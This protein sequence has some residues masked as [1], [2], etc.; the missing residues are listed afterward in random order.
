M[1]RSVL[2]K[3][4]YELLKGRK[5]NLAHLRA[6]GC[7]CFIHNND[8]DNLGK[9]YAKSDE[10]IFL[11]YSSQSKAY[12]VLNKRTNRV[13][14]SVHVVFNEHTSEVEGNSEDEQNEETCSKPSDP[15]TWEKETIPSEIGDKSA[16]ETGSSAP[17]ELVSI[18]THNWKHQSSH[19]LQN[20][21]TPLNSGISTRSKLRGMCAFSAYVSLIEPKN[22]K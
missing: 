11:G 19:P 9:F 22:I 14:E 20:L 7:V 4:P 2:N 6:F 16:D 3:T 13:E 17:Q 1:I 18:P 5:P 12:K 8:K 15:K 21:L 10:G